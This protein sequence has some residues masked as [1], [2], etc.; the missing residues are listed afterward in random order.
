MEETY[1]LT[2]KGHALLNEV[3]EQEKRLG[4]RLTDEEAEELLDRF[5]RTLALL[6]GLGL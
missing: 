5:S 2:E 1:G 4:R 6:D 3:D